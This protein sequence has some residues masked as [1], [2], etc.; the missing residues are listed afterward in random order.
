MYLVL[1]IYNIMLNTLKPFYSY[2]P[3]L[4]LGVQAQDISGLGL[5]KTCMCYRK[6]NLDFNG[7]IWLDFVCSNKQT[8]QTLCMMV[9][10]IALDSIKFSYLAL[11]MW[12]IT[13]IIMY[14]DGLNCRSQVWWIVL[15]LL[16][17]TRHYVCSCTGLYSTQNTKQWAMPLTSRWGAR[18]RRRWWGGRGGGSC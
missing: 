14:R 1:V 18:W 9:I 3:L 13:N 15:L 4:T 2:I 11:H 17:D 10:L 5:W 16:P 7:L 12:Q 6:H 8:L